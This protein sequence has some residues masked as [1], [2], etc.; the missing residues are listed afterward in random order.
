[1]KK[2]LYTL[3]FVVIG[4]TASYAQKPG[5]QNG[6]EES[7]PEVRAEKIAN[8][9]QQK[10]NLNSDQKS[11]IKQIELERIKKNDEWRRN[12]QIAMKNKMEERKTF[13]KAN[14]NK[15]DAVLTANQKK[16]LDES[17]SEMRIKMKDRKGKKGKKYHR[18]SKR[19]KNPTLPKPLN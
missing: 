18:N 6:R 11:K 17:R 8:S 14:K 2:L 7:T 13:M 12:D 3:A 9:W 5:R 4:F 15:V 19:G 1:M 10:L 16:T